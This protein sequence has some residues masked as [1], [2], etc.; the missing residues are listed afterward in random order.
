MSFFRRLAVLLGVVAI[1]ALLV[2]CGDTLLDTTNTEE[3]LETSLSKSLDEKVVSVDCPSDQKVEAG[4]TF[5]CSVK[6]QK[7]EERT[8]TLKIRNSDADL[9]IT[10]LSGGNE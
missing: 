8:V 9:S 4:A 6:L 1:V 7:G 10:K 5:S 3:Q 2:G